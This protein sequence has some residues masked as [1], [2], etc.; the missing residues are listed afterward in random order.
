[1]WFTEENRKYIT[2]QIKILIN[3]GLDLQSI[4]KKVVGVLGDILKCENLC[5]DFLSINT[6]VEI[7]I[8]VTKAIIAITKNERSSFLKRLFLLDSVK[9]NY[10]TEEIIAIHKIISPTFSKASIELIVRFLYLKQR[11][12]KMHDEGRAYLLALEAIINDLII[13]E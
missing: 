11:N 12:M 7:T 4:K 9:F 1:M 13:Y 10:T 5:G 8:E 2:T 3:K 6:N